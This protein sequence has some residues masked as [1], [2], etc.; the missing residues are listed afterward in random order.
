[1]KGHVTR[2]SS[3]ESDV[4]GLPADDATGTAPGADPPEPAVR[5]VGLTKRF[6]GSPTPAVDNLSLDIHDGEIVTLLGPSG[7]GKSTTLRMVAGLERADA[8]SIYFGQ[9]PVVITE[10]GLS[11]TPEK[12]RV[13]MVFQSYAIWPHMTVGQ[14]VAFPLKAQ[15]YPRKEIKDRV[16]HALE[17]VGMGGFGDRPGPLLSGGQQQR[18]A[19]AR[20]LVTEPRILLLDEPFSNLD[21][22]LR[23]QMRIEV[24]LLQQRLNIAALF[25]THDQ[26]EALGLSDRIVLMRAG[27]IQQ[28]GNARLLYERPAN[29]FVRDF[30]G[31][32]LLFKG[33]IQTRDDADRVG[34]RLDGAARTVVF[35][36]LPSSE[37]GE[38]GEPVRLAVR[39]EDLEVLPVDLALQLPR[40]SLT[41]EVEAALFV[42]ERIEYQIH[43]DGQDTIIAYGDRH[44]PIKAGSAVALRLRAKGHSV[45]PAELG[46]PNQHQ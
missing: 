24:K 39:P 12:R 9:R 4:A 38:I 2:G 3:A 14:N 22:K 25:V 6:P 36:R 16:E 23:E 40:E 5:L 11:L 33:V 43:V 31:K 8:G 35:G 1:M 18:V 37:K 15:K 41:G 28:Q 29:E 30:V 7:C 45:W 34:I 17:L 20:A 19:L 13:G 32:T 21:A 27:L 42:G 10:R 44:S 26:V 46:D